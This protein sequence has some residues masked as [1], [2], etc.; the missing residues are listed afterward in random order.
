MIKPYYNED[1]VFPHLDR[2]H[3]SVDLTSLL[4]GFGR[5]PMLDFNGRSCFWFARFGGLKHPFA[6]LENYRVP[7]DIRISLAKC[8]TQQRF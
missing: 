3:S 6:C 5:F 4:S 1:L 2:I 8:A 7:D